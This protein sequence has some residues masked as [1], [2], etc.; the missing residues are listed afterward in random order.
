MR[1]ENQRRKAALLEAHASVNVG[2]DPEVVQ[3][4]YVQ[5]ELAKAARKKQTQDLERHKRAEAKKFRAEKKGHEEE[6][7]RQ[8]EVVAR[9]A[10]E[11]MTAVRKQREE[12]QTRLHKQREIQ[13]IANQRAYR[14]RVSGEQREARKHE[15]KVQSL[16]KQEMHVC[17]AL[18]SSSC[19]L[20]VYCLTFSLL[21]LTLLRP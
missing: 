13:R 6:M 4:R 12:A 14:K 17:A 3:R 20:G 11:R 5:K 2:I 9:Q 7:R 16:E 1:E 18:C 21:G 8:R 10:K 15:R 19:H